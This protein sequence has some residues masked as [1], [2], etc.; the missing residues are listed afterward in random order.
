MCKTPL[1]LFVAAGLLLAAGEAR[2]V[3]VSAIYVAEEEKTYWEPINRGDIERVIEQTALDVLTRAGV[4]RLTKVEPK[5]LA[6]ARGDY[7]LRVSGRMVGESETHTIQLG[8]EAR[9]KAEV[10]SFRAAGT[11]V[12]GKIPLD[13]MRKRIEASTRMAAE[14]LLAVLKPALSRLTPTGTLDTAP[15]KPDDPKATLEVPT[16]PWSWGELR[17]PEPPQAETQELFGKNSERRAQTLR[18][19]ISEALVTPSRRNGL[20]HCATKHPDPEVRL[21]CLIGLRPSSRKLVPTQRVVINVFR[22]DKDSK[23]MQE[24]SSQMEYFSGM[25]RQEAIQAWL[26]RTGNTGRAHGPLKSLGDVPNLDAT[27]AR[28]FAAVHKMEQYQRTHR[29][30]IELMEPLDVKRRRAILWPYLKET[31]Q[32]SPAYLRGAGKGEGSSGTD[33]Q[34]GFEAVLKPACKLDP[35]LEDVL[36][37][38]YLRELSYSAIDA[39][40]DY[41]VPSEQLV[42]RL[43]Q[44]VQT[45]GERAGI[46]GLRRLYEQN[47]ELR[48]LIKNRVAEM[49]ATGNYDKAADVPWLEKEL[50]QIDRR[51]QDRKERSR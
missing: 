43:A 9:D 40:A 26:E 20:E 34:W 46:A 13:E 28:C 42:Q 19:L 51:E 37:Q 45:G 21:E 48:T 39:I 23:V 7:L 33:W 4:L 44:S 17:V 18:L 2:A 10:G 49:S 32:H 5:D 25:S 3:A 50:E 11:V 27:I 38:R 8:F 30:C 36:W 29:D 15:P 24:A 47:P 16:I 6:N 1:G 14:Q 12:I 35:Q 41:G 22:T 31:N